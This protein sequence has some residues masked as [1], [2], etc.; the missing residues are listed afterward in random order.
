MH[1][2]EPPAKKHHGCRSFVHGLDRWKFIEETPPPLNNFDPRKE[3][4]NTSRY[5]SLYGFATTVITVVPSPTT[6][7]PL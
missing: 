3:T 5:A 6:K 1:G 7:Q 4:T 2:S